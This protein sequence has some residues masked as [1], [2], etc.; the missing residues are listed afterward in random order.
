MTLSPTLIN[1][2]GRLL[3]AH[4]LAWLI[5]G[6]LLYGANYLTDPGLQLSRTL[7]FL[8]PFVLVFYGSL[9]LLR[10]FEDQE[11]GWIVAG[12]VIF[13][14][15]ASTMG[16]VYVYLILP[17]FGVE[18]YKSDQLDAFAKGAL[19]GFVQYFAY[20]LLYFFIERNFRK[21]TQLN[22]LRERTLEKEL[23][24]IRLKEADLR[25][26]QENLLLEH[27]FLRA[28]IN[29][30]FLHNTLNVLYAQAQEHSEQLAGNIAKLSRMMRYS[31][32]TTEEQPGR[33]PVEKELENLQL[34][35]EIHRMRF[36]DSR[37]VMFYLD[38][39][40]DGQMVPPLSMITMVENAMKYGDLN[41]PANPVLIS[42]VMR[43]NELHFR[44][45]N[46]ILRRMDL[47]PSTNRGLANLKR[48]LEA[49]FKD[50]YILSNRKDERFYNVEL[51]IYN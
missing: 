46:K 11:P 9:H 45:R 19:L 31:I 2:K 14:F 34:L 26:T 28:E 12:M 15:T 22:Q 49:N 48:R 8:L 16:H 6:S 17:A 18:L 29:P 44:C 30:H 3:F 5:Y 51:I 47:A 27:A 50:Q 43:S 4:L 21:R 37:L 23:E 39:K 38:G 13:F 33:V 10:S 36:R 20:A 40:P 35:L 25:V 7:L 41:D 32:E 24:N 1:R 42:L